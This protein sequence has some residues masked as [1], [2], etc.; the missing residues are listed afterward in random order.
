[1]LLACGVTVIVPE[2]E[3]IPDHPPDA[4]QELAWVDVQASVVLAPAT[5]DVGAAQMRAVGMAA[6]SAM[7]TAATVT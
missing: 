6:G 3:W 7:K 2:T 5:I 4:A 1:V